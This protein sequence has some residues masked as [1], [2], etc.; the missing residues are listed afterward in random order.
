MLETKPETYINIWYIC[1]NS[2]WMRRMRKKHS[3]TN[4]IFVGFVGLLTLRSTVKKNAPAS[5]SVYALR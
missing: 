2:E 1:E 4:N 5:V 3:V